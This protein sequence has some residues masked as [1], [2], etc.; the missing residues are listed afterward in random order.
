MGSKIKAKPKTLSFNYSPEENPDWDHARNRFFSLKRKQGCWSSSLFSATYKGFTTYNRDFPYQGILCRL[1]DSYYKFIDSFLFKLVDETGELNLTPTRVEVSPWSS[2]YFY[3]VGSKSKTV[4]AVKNYLSKSESKKL[5][6]YLQFELKSKSEQSI[7]LVVSPLLDIRQIYQNSPKREDYSY[8]NYRVLKVFQG[9]A[10]MIIGPNKNFNEVRDSIKWN[11]KLGDGERTK[12]KKVICFKS[13]KRRPIRIGN[14]TYKLKN[15]IKKKVGFVCGIDPTV[16][17]LNNAMRQSPKK[18]KENTE[19]L[20]QKF[21][22]E[23]SDLIEQ[24]DQEEETIKEAIIARI[25]TLDSFGKEVKNLT[26]PEA[27]E[28]WF[29]DVWARDLFESIFHSMKAYRKIKG[30]D[31]IRNVL[32][33][34]HKFIRKGVM[35]N[36]LELEG[37]N[38]Y[39]SLDG[40]F[41]YL[42]TLLKFMERTGRDEKLERITSLVLNESF[43]E[44]ELI[45]CKANYSWVD[46]VWNGKATRI[47]K[48]WEDKPEKEYLLP[49]V[50][51]LRLK[52]LDRYNKII[53]DKYHLDNLFKRYKSIFWNNEAKFI[54]QIVGP[55][56]KKDETASSVGVV[57][58]SLLDT[59]FSK[60]ELEQAW[61]TIQDNLMVYREPEI[62]KGDRL[63]FG[64]MVKNSEER[65][66]Y[67]DR[68]YHDS[69]VWLRDIPYLVNFLKKINRADIANKILKNSLDH[70]ISESAV[71]Y[72]Q[73]L[74]SPPEGENPSP[75][76]TPENPVPV[77]NPIQLWSHFVDQYL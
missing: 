52:A 42:L 30:D 45:K 17:D 63:P 25:K 36:K 53:E 21:S 65:V 5:S 38:S 44:E 11:Y 41:V 49:E 37:D 23:N 54:Y 67:N 50:N 46:S 59:F 18:E 19:K 9:K 47:P 73:E 29:K 26:M 39:K 62:L 7:N 28:W 32:L 10:S 57:S 55:S 1:E 3:Q 31:W 35:A 43:P 68:Q 14:L 64:V 69:T 61:K 71:L 22:L 16:K 60:E 12:K 58:L 27:G 40:T 20:R 77:K 76:S 74:F 13:K 6:G 8:Q 70:M 75:G 24:F 34:S 2:T 48:N 15:N 51:A 56:G 66:F 72:N 33:W 4:L